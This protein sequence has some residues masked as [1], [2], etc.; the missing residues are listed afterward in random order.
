MPKANSLVERM[1][2]LL[3]T[4]DLS[5]E[6]I[7]PVE[8]TDV[9]VGAFKAMLSFIYADDLS[10][11]N[12]DN[13]ISVL[14]AV[15]SGV[16]ASDELDSILLHYAHPNSVLPE[17]YPLQFPTKQRSIAAK[18]TIMLT[19]KKVSEFA[20]EDGRN[21][22]YSEYSEPIYL[23]GL[24]WV[25]CSTIV[26]QKKGKTDY[27]CEQR[28]IYSSKNNGWGFTRFISFEELM[29]P[30]NGW[31]DAENDTVMLTIDVTA[32]EPEVPLLSKIWRRY[33]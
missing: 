19:I 8:V 3:D 18:G 17:Q 20:R 10:G 29:D 12:G 16:L 24:P 33:W 30:N 23:R 6:E 28:H 13:A 32:E 26:P 2:H 4:G 31:Y 1:K 25:A 11:L 21:R 7:K 5:S 9:E 22:R 27:T 14:Q 15:P